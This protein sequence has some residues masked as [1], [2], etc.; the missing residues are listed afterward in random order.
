MTCCSSALLRSVLLFSVTLTAG[1][2]CCNPAALTG[3]G[4]GTSA[5]PDD[6][7]ETEELAIGTD[8][9][10]KALN[11]KGYGDLLTAELRKDGLYWYVEGTAAGKEGGTVKYI[12]MFNVTRF[13]NTQRWNVSTVSVNDEVVYP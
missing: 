5:K 10:Q 4:G 6:P 11:A 9:A 1:C 2:C 3:G 8:Y 7:A 12:V 13:D